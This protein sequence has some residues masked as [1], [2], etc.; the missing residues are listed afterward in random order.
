MVDV[1]VIDY[2][3]GN[4]HSASKALEFV[5][6]GKKIVVTSDRDQILAAERVMFPGV[7]AIRDCM[8]EIRRLGLDTLLPE[9][10]KTR[11]VLAICVGMQALMDLSEENQGVDCIGVLPGKVRFFGDHLVDENGE[12]L[13]VPHMGWN[14]VKQVQDHPIWHGIESDSRFY[15]VHSYYVDAEND[16]QIYGSTEYSSTFTSV[17]A[18]TNLFATQFHPEKSQHAGLALL[19]N[20]VNW[21]GSC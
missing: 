10:I 19:K 14:Q 5:A 11:P 2:G 20:F 18:D 9:L 16:Q 4:L 8:A 12:K 17:M 15:F 1:A 3:M 13:K 6:P 7:G 21:D